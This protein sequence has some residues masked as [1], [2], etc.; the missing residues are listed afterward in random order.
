VHLGGPVAPGRLA[1]SLPPVLPARGAAGPW[2]Q[3]RRQGAGARRARLLV[4]HSAHGFLTA[5]SVTIDVRHAG[6]ASSR[7]QP[8]LRSYGC[9][10]C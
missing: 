8:S 10:G 4:W 2:V 7:R 6:S 9:H 5:G 1:R 3:A